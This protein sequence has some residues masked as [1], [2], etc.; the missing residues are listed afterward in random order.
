MINRIVKITNSAKLINGIVS[1]T[2][3]R[4]EKLLSPDRIYL[5]FLLEMIPPEKTP[6]NMKRIISNDKGVIA[7]AT[8][9][10]KLATKKRINAKKI[11]LKK[12]SILVSIDYS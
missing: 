9:L 4:K 6:S 12:Y 1:I 11:R 5:I 8:M 7:N 10:D 2:F 3:L